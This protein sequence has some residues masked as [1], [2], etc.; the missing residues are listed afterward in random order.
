MMT[1][2]RPRSRFAVAARPRLHP[3]NGNRRT[4]RVTRRPDDLSR[5]SSVGISRTEAGVTF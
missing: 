2:R 1:V 4:H 5:V 3:L